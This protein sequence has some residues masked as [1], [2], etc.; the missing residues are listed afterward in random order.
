[1]DDDRFRPAVRALI[2]LVA[3]LAAPVALAHTDAAAGYRSAEP[4]LALVLLVAGVLYVLGFRAVCRSGRGNARVKRCVWAFAAAWIVLMIAIASPLA[5]TT[6]GLFSAHMVQH[7]L[8]M[9]VAAPLMVLGRPLAIW[10]WALPI[11]ARRIVARPFRAS[12]LSAAWRSLSRP[13]AATFL[14]A[15]AIWTWHVPRAFEAAETSF[16]AHA[17][18]H[19]A[20]LFSALLFWWVVLRPGR[21]TGSGSAVL[22]LFV[23]MLHTGALGVLLTFSGEVWY[24]LSTEAAG[25]WGLTPLEDQ[26]LGGLVMWVP[27]GL[28]YIA[29]ALVLAARWLSEGTPGGTP[30]HRG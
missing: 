25:A 19:S 4:W 27:G 21:S 20:F 14:H 7:E 11:G 6:Q 28:P 22:C 26:Q 12:P 8:L 2:G 5:G 15:A 13:A 18:Q 1:M 3:A 9:T 30:V 24:P 23:T 10:T 29:A 16:V 17:L